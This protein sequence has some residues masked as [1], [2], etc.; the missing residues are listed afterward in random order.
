MIKNKQ[1]LNPEQQIKQDLFSK[2][3]ND[4]LLMYVLNENNKLITKKN[5][6]NILLK[7]GIQYQVKDIE[8][9]QTAMVHESY[10]KRDYKID[11][12]LRLLMTKDKLNSD[13]LHTSHL[14]DVTLNKEIEPIPHNMIKK[15][16]PLFDK[17][18]QRLEYLGDSVIRLIFAAYLYKRYADQYEGFL[19]RLRTKLENGEKLAEISLKIGLNEH[20]IIGRYYEV[21][22]ARLENHHILEDLLE[23]FI[24]AL[25]KDG[26]HGDDDFDGNYDICN[27]FF[28]SLIESELDIAELLHTETNYKDTLLQYHH[29]IKWGDPEYGMIEQSGTEKRI[30]KMFVKDGY[31]NISGIGYG[32]SKKKGEQEAAKNALIKYGEI[33]EES[34]DEELYYEYDES[35]NQKNYNNQTSGSESEYIYD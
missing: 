28:V 19:T 12:T 35:T 27:Q 14:H 18:Y 26:H 3:S 17:S 34:D 24:G 30:F 21:Q 6:E 22:N 25:F 4:Q 2:L 33:K 7:Y 31:N 32:S 13:Q 29:K 20:M 10:I 23:A 8:I 16:I 5:I 1:N 15:T 11:K 9:F